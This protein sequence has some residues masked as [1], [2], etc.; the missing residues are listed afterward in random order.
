MY[1]AFGFLDFYKVLGVDRKASLEEIREGFRH[2]AL[3]Y[4]PDKSG[5]GATEEEFKK[6]LHAYNV[7]TDELQRCRHNYDLWQRQ[8][9]YSNWNHPRQE[10]GDH[11]QEPSRSQRFWSWLLTPGIFVTLVRAKKCLTEYCQTGFILVCTLSRKSGQRMKLLLILLWP[12]MKE[13][14]IMLGGLAT[15]LVKWSLRAFVVLAWWN[16]K[17]LMA[18]LFRAFVRAPGRPIQKAICVGFAWQIAVLG[19]VIG[20]WPWVGWLMLTLIHFSLILIMFGLKVL[21]Y[22]LLN[23]IPSPS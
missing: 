20:I 9:R 4:H 15:V 5:S 17:E 18:E 7:L 12:L 1:E 2:L 6:I 10:E 22:I 13:C 14:A 11:K 21:I 23:T 19:H 8:Q 3:R 16:T